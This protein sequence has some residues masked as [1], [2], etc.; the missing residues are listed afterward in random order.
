MRDLIQ[1]MG[2]GGIQISGIE[3]RGPGARAC[4]R[5]AKM[6]QGGYMAEIVERASNINGYPSN[7][8]S[9]VHQHCS[10]SELFRKFC[11]IYVRR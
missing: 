1:A 2:G 5:I 11:I 10:P 3:R 7:W 8:D 4:A 9:W 6:D